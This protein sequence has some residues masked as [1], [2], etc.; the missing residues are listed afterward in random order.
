MDSRDISADSGLH[1][2]TKDEA[3]SQSF[4]HEVPTLD[5][6][7]DSRRSNLDTLLHRFI[8]EPFDPLAVSSPRFGQI[9]Q[10]PEE[11]RV[12]SG[13][14]GWNPIQPEAIAGKSTV[15][16]GCVLTPLDIPGLGP[17]VDL[18]GQEA[19][20]RFPPDTI[21]ALR[22]HPSQPI[23]TRTAE[24]PKQQRLG[25]I[26]RVMCS[27]DPIAAGLGGHLDQGLAPQVA[28]RFLDRRSLTA[29]SPNSLG[30]CIDPPGAER[31]PGRLG[32]LLHVPFVAIRGRIS[33]TMIDVPHDP[34]EFELGHAKRNQIQQHHRIPTAGDGDQQT[35]LANTLALEFYS[36]I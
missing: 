7:S 11:L 32:G 12:E 21:W 18:V 23:G 26:A 9:A 28:R 5:R 17:G 34:R 6:E 29:R 33:Q 20:Q 8:D 2:A 15:L 4:G 1:Q 25:L 16:I 3:P 22:R 14:K 36:K 30:V 19:K 13:R 10:R 24:N 31:E 27:R 35:T